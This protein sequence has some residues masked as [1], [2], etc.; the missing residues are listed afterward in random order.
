MQLYIKKCQ[1]H[2]ICFCEFC[3]SLEGQSEKYASCF[4]KVIF[5]VVSEVESARPNPINSAIFIG[6][7]TTVPIPLSHLNNH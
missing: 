3:L 5:N 4:N 6:Q 1:R 7:Y 2:I